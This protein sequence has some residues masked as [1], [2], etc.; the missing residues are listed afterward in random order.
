M[1]DRQGVSRQAAQRSRPRGKLQP[2]WPC[3]LPSVVVGIAPLRNLTGDLEHQCLLDDFTDRLVIEQFRRCRG[4][5]FSWVPGE[6]HR[7][8]NLAPPSPS[9]LKYVISGS[10]QR[11]SL[12]GKL[13]VNL[14]VSDPVTA[15]YLWAGR[16]EF[17][18]EDL[19]AI[20]TGIARQVS[21]A[22]HTLVLSEASHRA[23]V[24]SGMGFGVAECL[25]R[26]KA[27]LKRELCAE[28][29]AKAQQWF[30]SALTL[31]PHNVEALVGV[32]LTCQHLVSNPWW[33]DRRDVAA[34]ADLGR[35]AVTMA[36]ELKPRYAPAQ[37][38]LG[39]LYSAA[40]Q[41]EEAA[42]AFRQALIMDQ[43]LAS[44]HAFGGYNA[45]LLGHA[46]DTAQAVQQAMHLNSTDR[47]H[48]IFFFFAGF[49]E[50]LLGRTDEA[51]MLLQKSLE[52]NPTYGSPQLFLMAALSLS[53]RRSEATQL[54][55][56]FRQKYTQS[57]A[58]AF[59]QFWLS[60]SASPIYR[61][62][63]FSLFED[64]RALSAAS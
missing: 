55:K 38:I 26:A 23:S 1:P 30:L 64:I 48:S 3:L 28:L 34:A 40:G 19:A 17:R 44:A 51:V 18:R 58:D 47:G 24:S 25:T 12:H 2:Q 37:C 15:H 16:Q 31:D 22:L 63:V 5:S 59:E 39:M 62:Q 21:R 57:P 20:Q 32:A 4:F 36:L 11:G 29:S 45:A 56:S 41:L 43:G 7:S 14:R 49:A 54:E 46:T 42:S 13:R 60:R 6:R 27:A 8:P 52:R 35:E 61:A 53:G 10:I 50:L 33:G 9:E